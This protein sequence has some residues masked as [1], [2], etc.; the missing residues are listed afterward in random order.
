M[1]MAGDIKEK[2]PPDVLDYT[3]N[4]RKWL[5]EGDTVASAIATIVA[6]G[7]APFTF[8]VDSVDWDDT[9]VRVWISGGLDG[10]VA[11]VL[12]TATTAQLRTK[13]DCFTLRIKDC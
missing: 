13:Q 6:I 1:S 10:E 11:E 4:F 2:T 5:P 8:V 3:K 9:K 12:I 7:T